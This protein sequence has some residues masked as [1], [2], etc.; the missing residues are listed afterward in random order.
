LSAE[1]DVWV[2][3]KAKLG[4]AADVSPVEVLSKALQRVE[5]GRAVGDYLRDVRAAIGGGDYADLAQEAR[6]L[7]AKAQ[8]S[9]DNYI[10]EKNARVIAERKVGELQTALAHEQVTVQTAAEELQRAKE[11]ER[12][13]MTLAST[14]HALERGPL[15]A[16]ARDLLLS[17][18]NGPVIVSIMESMAE[19][20]KSPA[21]AIAASAYD[22]AEALAAEGTR[23]Y[24]AATI[25][26]DL[27]KATPEAIADLK[28]ERR[29]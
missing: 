18:A 2:Q 26:V 7:L 22:L 16:L 19:D 17:F 13:W 9:H 15:D 4:L 23:R 1:A 24:E 10:A 21:Q 3:L 27:S 11:R 12:K 14:P 5:E 29:G 25:K 20:E 28:T 6:G 8:T